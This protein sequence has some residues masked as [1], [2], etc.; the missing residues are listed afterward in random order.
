MRLIGMFGLVM[1]TGTT[2]RPVMTPRSPFP[3]QMTRLRLLFVQ[4]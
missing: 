1:K 4:T 3:L 2:A